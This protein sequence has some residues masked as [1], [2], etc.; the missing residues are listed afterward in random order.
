MSLGSLGSIVAYLG[1]TPPEGWLLCNGTYFDKTQHP[2]LADILKNNITPDLQDRFLFGTNDKNLGQFAGSNLI[3]LDEY[4][5][6]THTVTEDPYHYQYGFFYRTVGK[7]AGSVTTHVWNGSTGWT[8][9]GTN[10]WTPQTYLWAS[11]FHHDHQTSSGHDT[12]DYEMFINYNVAVSYIVYT[13]TDFVEP[14]PGTVLFWLNDTIPAGYVAAE[15]Q[16]TSPYPQ[17]NTIIDTLPDSSEEFFIRGKRPDETAGTTSGE[18]AIQDKHLPAHTHTV[19]REKPKPGIG[20]LANPT[21]V[22]SGVNATKYVSYRGVANP[23]VAG[24]VEDSYMYGSQ[25]V[26]KM[27]HTHTLGD[28]GNNQEYLPLHIKSKILVKT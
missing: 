21:R 24:T 27:P 25:Y 12:Q 3:T 8:N 18:K 15:G 10:Y 23:P 26:A 20:Y 22:S 9:A 19:S 13:K 4:P 16:S 7:T 11:N 28:Y 17:L 1:D 2:E 14:P 6:H 5:T